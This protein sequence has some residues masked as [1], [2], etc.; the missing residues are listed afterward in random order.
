[1][2]LFSAMVNH[3]AIVPPNGHFW[4]ICLHEKYW[5]NQCGVN[6]L[7]HWQNTGFILQSIIRRAT[8]YKT[9]VK[10]VFCHGSV[11]GP[12]FVKSCSLFFQCIFPPQLK[13]IILE[14][15]SKSLQNRE[16][17]DPNAVLSQ[18]FMQSTKATKRKWKCCS[19]KL[20]KEAKRVSGGVQTNC[21]ILQSS[22]VNKTFCSVYYII[23]GVD[24]LFLQC[25]QIPATV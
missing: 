25:S 5:I 24:S 14:H 23:Y 1:M 2:A 10:P 7:Q 13:C 11:S 18:L 16:M 8:P 12:V 19:N 21:H 9:P 4:V 17:H 22:A 15:K 3:G 6:I 20:L